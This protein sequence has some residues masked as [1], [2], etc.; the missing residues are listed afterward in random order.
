MTTTDAVAAFRATEPHDPD[1]PNYTT[2][3]AALLETV[4]DAGLLKR[5]IP[6]Y[7]FLF[8]GLVLALGGLCAG[9]FLLGSSWFQLLIAA[10]LGIVLTQFAFMAHEAAHRR[11][12]RSWQGSVTSGG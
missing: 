3:Y 5:R 4:R 12:E 6:F 10:V 9:F 2:A 11:S 7:A 8:S 1:R